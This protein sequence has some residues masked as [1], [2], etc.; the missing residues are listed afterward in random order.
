MASSPSGRHMGH[1]KT[2]L[3]NSS[4]P[5]IVLLIAHMSLL[6]SFP[7]SSALQVMLEKGKG[8]YIENLHI[9]QL[10]EADLYFVLHVIWGKCLLHHALHNLEKA[11]F[12]ILGQT[13]HNAV[14]NKL[15]FL[16]L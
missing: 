4:I 1:Y 14:L 7:I 3:K 6:T 16:D 12:D 8:R 11:Q 5:K 9:I 13:C 15:I 2:M 10:C